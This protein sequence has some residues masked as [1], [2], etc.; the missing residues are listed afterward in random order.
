MSKSIP[1][2]YVWGYQPQVGVASGASQDY[3]TRMNWLSA[4]PGMISRVNQIRE[5]QND[6][7]LK[8]ALI[9]ETPRPVMNPRTWPADLIIDPPNAPTVVQLPRNESAELA[10]TDSGLQL[11]GGGAVMR[12]RPISGPIYGS[13]LRGGSIQLSSREDLTHYRP[14]RLRSDGQ[15]QLAG[16]SRVILPQQGTLLLQGSSSRPRSGGIGALQFTQE[17]VPTVYQN[18]FSGP[19]GVYPDEFIYNYDLLSDSVNGY[20]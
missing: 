5:E 16:G 2:P 3:S 6:I 12:F 20:S 8:Q 13:G 10:M 4:G 1:T 9:T 19:P 15:F 7:L 11:A 14:A 17:F 18:P